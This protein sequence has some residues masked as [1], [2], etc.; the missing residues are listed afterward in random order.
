[1]S[2]RKTSF[3]RTYLI[4]VPL[5]ALLT[6]LLI[7]L[8]A[9]LFWSR[10]N[11][12][13]IDNVVN[14]FVGTT[15]LSLSYET[16]PNFKEKLVKTLDQLNSNESISANIK[17]PDG[18]YLAQIP[19][20]KQEKVDKAISDTPGLIG[21]ED[22]LGFTRCRASVKTFESRPFNGTVS[23]AIVFDDDLYQIYM[24]YPI[25]IFIS[26]GA[27]LGAGFLFG[28]IPASISRKKSAKKH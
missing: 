8:G 6:F 13:T 24:Q 19:A 20:E 27:S 9:R 28:L 21:S 14:K 23:V 12:R 15:A 18:S 2:S 1:M 10:N 5:I 4:S 25:V 7:I 11:I 26:I 3:G 22:L 17:L 16:D